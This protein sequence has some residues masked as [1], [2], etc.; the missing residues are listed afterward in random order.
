[1]DAMDIV[2]E[3][4]LAPYPADERSPIP[5]TTDLLDFDFIQNCDD[6]KVIRC[7]LR[8]LQGRQDGV[9]PDLERETLDRLVLLSPTRVQAQVKALR[10]Q[11]CPVEVAKEEEILQ[12][13]SD[14]ME[15]KDAAMGMKRGVAVGSNR[16]RNEPGVVVVE[17]SSPPSRSARTIITTTTTNSGSATALPIATA[18]TAAPAG[19]KASATAIMAVK[20]REEECEDE[21][22]DEKVQAAEK[23]IRDMSECL[24]HTP[25]SL[26]P[27]LAAQKKEDGNKLLKQGE[28][29]EARAAYTLSLGHAPENAV[30][31]ANRALAMLKQGIFDQ[32]EADCTMAINREPSYAKAWLRRGMIRHKMEK[33]DK[34]RGDLRQV[35]VVCA[36][37]AAPG[38]MKGGSGKAGMEE[39]EA[40]A[41]LAKMDKEDGKKE[42]GERVGGGE[43]AMPPPSSSSPPHLPPPPPAADSLVD[44]IPAVSAGISLVEQKEEKVAVEEQDAGEERDNPDSSN[45]P[46]PQSAAVAVAAVGAA[47]TEGGKEGGKDGYIW[48]PP[49]RP[50]FQRLPIEEVRDGKYVTKAQWQQQQQRQGSSKM[51]GSSAK[52]S[53]SK[54]HSSSRNDRAHILK[55]QGNNALLEKNYHSAIKHYTEAIA[56]DAANSDSSNS[57]TTT[58]FSESNHNTSRSS[59]ATTTT[60]LSLILYNNRAQ[61]HL[62]LERW[63]EAFR[64]ASFVLDQDPGNIKARFR[65]GKALCRG[66]AECLATVEALW[67]KK[68]AGKEAREEV[69]RARE[70]EAESMCVVRKQGMVGRAKEGLENAVKEM[71]MIL[72]VESGNAEAQ[73][74]RRLAKSLLS[75][76]QQLFKQVGHMGAAGVVGASS[77]PPSSS[78][79]PPPNELKTILAAH[80]AEMAGEERGKEGGTS[81]M[82]QEVTTRPRVP[83]V[84]TFR[85]IAVVEEGRRQEQD[86]QQERRRQGQQLPITPLKNSHSSIFP[87]SSS[88]SVFSSVSSPLSSGKKKIPP[89]PTS[90]SELETHWRTLKKGGDSG[91]TARL[92]SYLS[93]FRPQTFSKVIKRVTS[94]DT[95]SEIYAV[96][97]RELCKEGEGGGMEG[98][99][100]VVK[101]VLE[102]M[103]GAEGFQLRMSMMSADDLENVKKAF[104]FL[105][106]TDTADGGA[107]G[108]ATTKGGSGGKKGKIRLRALRR[109]Y[110]E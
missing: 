104:D 51:D 7:I 88:S 71:N 46:G 89:P 82:M 53:S 110:F 40:M 50:G 87:S 1:M 49:V 94:E 16:M 41:L 99:R 108:S 60:K 14:E 18:T 93:S 27:L 84:E 81:S 10:A 34:A 45:T 64:D 4:L 65:K 102:G 85:K 70:K 101:R 61:A 36:A 52:S 39:K 97:A 92:A 73:K 31:C 9:Y 107:D 37:A 59:T 22:E 75:Q 78:P 100:E 105:G 2:S 106:A 55:E 11:P 28:Y 63:E 29:S 83:P 38:E 74:E 58:Y 43:P 13:W 5:I 8:R 15:R 25:L 33:R 86:E 66:G 57:S 44:D 48:P 72:A 42:E 69:L 3:L 62:K 68:E 19:T 54:N 90:I 47:G 20:E 26:R 30:V 67:K 76:Y 95:I 109:K 24:R 79:H 21:D 98:R 6:P 17:S 91:S 80:R 35:L 77:I 12:E 23:E 32:A 103:A 56:A 96:L